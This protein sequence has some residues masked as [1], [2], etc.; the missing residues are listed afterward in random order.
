MVEL[1]YQEYGGFVRYDV[2]HQGRRIGTIGPASSTGTAG[3]LVIPL[4]P[5][6][7]PTWRQWFATLEEAQAWIED[8]LEDFLPPASGPEHP[9]R[10]SDS[11]DEAG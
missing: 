5:E 11:T 2:F 9:S 10:Q 6:H 4:W 8:H 3:Y 7:A 1:R